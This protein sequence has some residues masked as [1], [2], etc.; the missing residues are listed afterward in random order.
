MLPTE[1]RA[2][3]RP[4]ATSRARIP[5]ASPPTSQM[6]AA[7]IARASTRTSREPTKSGREKPLPG[8]SEGRPRWFDFWLMLLIGSATFLILLYAGARSGHH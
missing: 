2:G 6:A 8:S 1:R 5:L 7:P 4:H 3:H